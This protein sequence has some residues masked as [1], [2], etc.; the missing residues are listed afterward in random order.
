MKGNTK[1]LLIFEILIIILL[2]LNNF[3]SSILR[4]YTEV[5]FLIGLLVIFYFILG[6]TKDRHYLWKNVCLE[7]IIYL[8][9][10][11]MLYYLLGVL[12]S[13][14]KINNYY[15]ISGFTKVILPL[16]LAIILK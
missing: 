10:F 6:F 16:V 2:L 11:F 3:V 8:L 14:T 15:N 9:I 5:I 7:I 12:I 1:K 4:G 13:F